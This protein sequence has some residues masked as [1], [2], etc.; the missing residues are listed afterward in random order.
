MFSRLSVRAHSSLIVALTC[1]VAVLAAVLALSV[2]SW[3]ETGAVQAVRLMYEFGS[4][5]ELPGNYEKLRSLVAEEDFEKLSLDNELRVVNTYFKF[6]TLPATVEVLRSNRNF[7]AYT[8]KSESDG[9]APS[10]VWVFECEIKAGKLCNIR[11][12]RCSNQTELGSDYFDW[13]SVSAGRAG[14]SLP[15]RFY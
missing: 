1:L 11:E 10:T 5:E 12:Y 9:I 8:L 3:R 13:S 2:Y 4:V 14:G 15:F 6:Q 7:V